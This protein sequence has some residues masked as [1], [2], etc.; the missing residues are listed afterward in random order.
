[1]ADES[2]TIAP[3]PHCGGA[4]TE[5]QSVCPDCGAGPFA[6]WPPAIT[7]EPP[8]AKPTRIRLLTGNI[9]LDEMLGLGFCWL[10]MAGL[11]KSSSLLES[12]YIAYVVRLPLSQKALPFY[13]PWLGL[14]A[15]ALTAFGCA[16]MGLRY[17]YPKI[18]RG[19]G[20]NALLGG[21]MALV[22]FLWLELFP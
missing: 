18:G 1:M 15:L 4:V 5:A 20:Q 10:L 3:C 21:G 7:A 2:P 22:V 13:L 8:E 12:T 11:G 17:F 14:S 9:W 19:F 16:Y 6:V